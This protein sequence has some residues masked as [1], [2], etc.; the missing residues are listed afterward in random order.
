MVSSDSH[1]ATYPLLLSD[2]A[3]AGGLCLELF[4]PTDRNPMHIRGREDCRHAE[5]AQD[6]ARGL[7]E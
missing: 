2:H 1:Y 7:I 4:E 3:R 5:T 6:Q